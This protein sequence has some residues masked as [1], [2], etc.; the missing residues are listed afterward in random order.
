[1][2]HLEGLTQSNCVEEKI[3]ISKKLARQRIKKHQL[4]NIPKNQSFLGP[5]V[6]IGLT[7]LSSLTP[8]TTIHIHNPFYFEATFI[9]SLHM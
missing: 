2:S 6:L 1:M 3:W 8:L 5:C 4:E 7:E 9:S